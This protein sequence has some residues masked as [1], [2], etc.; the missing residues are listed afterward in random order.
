MNIR[1][2]VMVIL[3]SFLVF[4]SG[5]AFGQELSPA[6]SRDRLGLWGRAPRERLF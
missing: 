5:A 2:S 4:G 6:E 3:G 1:V